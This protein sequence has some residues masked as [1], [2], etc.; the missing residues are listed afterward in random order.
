[1]IPRG[2]NVTD[3]GLIICACRFDYFLLKGCVA[4]ARHALGDLP[5]TVFI[6][7]DLDPRALIKHYGVKVMYRREV[8]DPWLRTKNTGWGLPKMTLFWESPYETFLY[9]DCDTIFWGDVVKA[10]LQPFDADLIIDPGDAIARPWHGEAGSVESLRREYFDPV[11]MEQACPSFPWKKYRELFFCTGVFAARRGCLSLKR[12]REIFEMRQQTPGLLAPSGEMPMLNLLIF[13]A[14]ERGEVKVKRAPLQFVCETNSESL[15]REAFSC[16]PAGPDLSRHAPVV[17]HFTDPKPLA[18]SSGFKAPVQY[19]RE[20]CLC[21]TL[22]LPGL[23]AH[24]YTRFEEI[25]WRMRVFYR[26]NFGWMHVQLRGLL[27]KKPRPISE[28]S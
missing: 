23:L 15:A 14:E 20:K 22:G 10:Y 5:I 16:G 24:L 17:L 3:F 9:V 26:R 1:M 11:K 4:S 28:A 8:R 6:D 27:V 13:E 12:Y 18:A 2:D 7:D 25:N 21:A 19:F